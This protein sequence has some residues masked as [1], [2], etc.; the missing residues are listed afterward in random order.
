MFVN[1][2]IIIRAET[3]ADVHTIAEVTVSAFET[4]EIS[5]HT[6]Q[7]IIAALRAANALTVSLVAESDGRVVGHVAFSPVVISDGTPD[8]YALGPISVLPAYQRQGIGKTLIK[9]GLSRLKRLDAKGCCLVGHPGYY[10]KFGFEN[11]D[12]FVHEGVPRE[13]FQALSF[14]GRFPQGT[15]TFHDA[16]KADGRNG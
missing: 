9:G 11:I 12:G 8:W 15:V 6:E 2:N 4:L 16:Y 5:N 1:S 14:D 7:F 3:D 13:V 10:C